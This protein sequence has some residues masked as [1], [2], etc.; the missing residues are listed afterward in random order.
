M[1]ACSEVR[2]YCF[3][4]SQFVVGLGPFVRKKQDTKASTKHEAA[5]HDGAW[6]WL[7]RRCIMAKTCIL[8]TFAVLV[9]RAR[10]PKNMHGAR[11]EMQYP[12]EYCW[13]FSSISHPGKTK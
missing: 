5:N 9:G 6:D 3:S 13:R 8:S 12:F 11:G 4:W 7:Q 2:H 10:S 1:H